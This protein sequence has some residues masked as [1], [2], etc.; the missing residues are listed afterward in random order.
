MA[1]ADACEDLAVSF[2][3]PLLP[4][5]RPMP[6]PPQ[7]PWIGP[8]E[9]V[10]GAGVGLEVVLARTEDVGI[11]VSGFVAEPN[12]VS[13]LLDFRRRFGAFPGTEWGRPW[14]PEHPHAI[15]QDDFRFGVALPDG[16]K[17]TTLH[18]WQD[19]DP[20][21]AMPPRLIPRGGS[22]GGHY[23]CQQGYWLWPL[24]PAGTLAFVCQWP[25][26]GIGLTRVEIDSAPILAAAARATVLWDL[27]ERDPEARAGWTTY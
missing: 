18:L 14:P 23:S 4:P 22:G 19:P 16:R 1:S 26:V 8:A 12:G 11:G 25:A 9:N 6:D 27:P 13:F 20:S 15:G 17:V 21:E 10:L 7:P 3:D 2:F 24:P 5:P